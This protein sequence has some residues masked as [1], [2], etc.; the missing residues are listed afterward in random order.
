MPKA[1]PG[2][3]KVYRF[4]REPRPD[5][6]RRAT[7]PTEGE[8]AELLTG[9]VQGKPA[10]DIEERLGRAFGGAENVEGYRF[11]VSYFAGQN[12]QGEYRLDYLVEADGL[13]YAIN[14][15]GEY[16]HKSAEQKARDGV[17]DQRLSERL[18]GTLAA[19][20]A[21]WPGLGLVVN[22]LVTR[23]PGILLDDQAA[24]NAL[25]KEMF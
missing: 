16:A 17:Q 6:P 8:A 22:G 9:Q 7:G 4:R 21:H 5:R 20:P 19:P 1:L 3:A 10:S 23:I 25:V 11:Q 24:A 14:P 13:E 18:A 2:A 12:I 15:D